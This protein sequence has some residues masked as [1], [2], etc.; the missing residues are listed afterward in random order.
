[1]LSASSYGHFS[2]AKEFRSQCHIFRF[3]NIGYCCEIDIFMD[4]NIAYCCEIDIFID[5]NI[6]YCCEIDISRLKKAALSDFSGPP[7]FYGSHRG[8]T[9]SHRGATGDPGGTSGKV[10]SLCWEGFGEVTVL[11]TRFL[12]R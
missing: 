3:G 4:Q 12:Y 11:L 8:A 2:S 5:Q 9:G 10:R 1:M 6:A 7:G